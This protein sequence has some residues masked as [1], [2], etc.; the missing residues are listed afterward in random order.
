[1]GNALASGSLW[2]FGRSLD[3]FFDDAV[4]LPGWAWALNTSGRPA[5]LAI[6]LS[7]V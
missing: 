1:V 6:V 7:E 2:S 5:G 4:A 3:E